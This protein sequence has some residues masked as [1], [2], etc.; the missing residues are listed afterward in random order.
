MRKEHRSWLVVA[1]V[2]A[3]VVFLGIRTLGTTT[4]AQEKRV[5]SPQ[6]MWRPIKSPGAPRSLNV[7]R[8]KVPGGWLVLVS[9]FR[10]K[11]QHN[12]SPDGYGYGVGIGSG[13][14]FV[15]DPEH[16]WRTP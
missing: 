6:F 11:G 13:V 9:E 1:A 7:Y 14:T 8:T 15:P 2:T 16:T 4:Q 12:R 10:E 3:L 5:P